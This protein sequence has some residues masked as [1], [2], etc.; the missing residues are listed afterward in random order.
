MQPDI[1]V[2]GNVAMCEIMLN[3]AGVLHYH[4]DRKKQKEQRIMYNIYFATVCELVTSNGF[5]IIN[6]GYPN[7]FTTSPNRITCQQY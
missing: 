6:L 5:N 4:L 2:V 7:I 1:I 3:A